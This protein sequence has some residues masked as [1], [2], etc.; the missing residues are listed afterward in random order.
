MD[1]RDLDLNLLVVLRQLLEERHVSRA[2]EQ[3][4]MSQPAVSRALQRLRTLFDDPLLVRTSGG[5]VPSARAER[6]LPRLRQLLTETARLVADPA[7]DPATS[8]QTV[9]FHGPEPEIGWFLPPLFARMSQLAPGMV[10]EVQSE[11]REH[12][13]QLERG[14]VHFVLSALTPATGAGELHRTPLAPLTFALVMHANHPLARGELTLERYI[15]ARHGLVSLTSRGGGLLGQELVEQGLLAPGERL[16]E[17]L[18]L[19]SFSSIAAF[20]EHSD[21]VFRLPRR[22]AETLSRGRAL[23]VREAPTTTTL[24]R[25]QIHLYWHERFHRDP[26]CLWIRHQLKAAHGQSV[27]TEH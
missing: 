27:D 16:N 23:V 7:F 10:L 22:F 3:L 21:V 19:S 13:G 24:D 6:L 17:P 20:C 4:G 25:P 26:M 12:F 1:L 18:R 8:T 5:Y 11:P 14:E 2:A 15:A 9:R